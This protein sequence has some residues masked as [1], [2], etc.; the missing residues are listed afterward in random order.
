MPGFEGENANRYGQ[1]INGLRRMAGVFKD[2]FYP[3]RCLVCGSFFYHTTGAN[4][5]LTAQGL[6][7]EAIAVFE[8]LLAPFLCQG[9]LEGFKAVESPI[10]LQ[11][12]VMFQSRENDDHICGNCLTWPKKFGMARSA[13]LYDRAL[14]AAIHCMKYYG[15]IQLAR[16]PGTLLFNT[17]TR[18]WPKGEIDLVIPVP[19][20]ITK[21][22]MRGFNQAF[23]LIRHWRS[24][25]GM[26]PVSRP[27]IK[28]DQQTLIRTKRA[29]PQT[30][31]SRKKRLTN[32]KN[33]F[34]LQRSKTISGQ[35]ILLVDDVYTTGA[36]VNECAKVLLHGGAESVDVLTLAQAA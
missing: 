26:L 24:L 7:V 30:G 6:P 18:Y 35:R 14:M 17:F 22:R 29:R 31:L 36:T 15:K 9:C 2:A 16:P 32:I 12:G 1:V 19:L 10:C 20:H 11:C 23:L 5:G 21:M 33:A 28:I 25:A 34:R 27:A 4:N 3:A 8:S 13:G